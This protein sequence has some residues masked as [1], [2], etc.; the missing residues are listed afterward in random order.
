MSLRRPTPR[1]AMALFFLTLGLNVIIFQILLYYSVDLGVI[2][3][4]PLAIL[5]PTLVA[6]RLL[7]ADGR[8][9]LRWKMPTMADVLLA[10]PLAV[11]LAVL[12]DQLSNLTAQIF[13]MSEEFLERMSDLLRAESGLDWVMKLLGIGLGAAV[14]EEL[15][16][17][18]FMLSAF[19]TR[20]GRGSAILYT[21]ALFALMHLIPQGLLSYALAGAVLG[22]TAAATGSILVPILIHFT[23][24]MWAVALLSLADMDSLGR[25]IWIPPGIL[26]PALMIFA[27]TLVHYTRK[28]GASAPEGRS[29][30]EERSSMGPADGT[31][32]FDLS[33]PATPLKDELEGIPESRRRLGWLTVGCAVII[34]TAIIFGL[35]SWSIYLASGERA[36]AALVNRIEED[37]LAS[38][39]PE[40]E[41]LTP[42]IRREFEALGAAAEAGQL[43]LWQIL[44]VTWRYAQYQA[45]GTL[46]RPEVETLLEEVRRLH[47]SSTGLRRL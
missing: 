10:I 8:R 24:N 36:H 37:L 32:R 34:G 26:I 45:D 42:S 22:I 39:S 3:A 14:S 13:P 25:P 41:D 31:N 5:V 35:F 1:A 18:G 40:D 44:G 28:L 15:L 46:T 11:S 29:S 19:E 33:S 9:T 27:L 23:N 12:N 47:E 30:F 17:R 7:K 6:V 20:Y 16:F 38:L 21:S 2:L 4:E 43:S